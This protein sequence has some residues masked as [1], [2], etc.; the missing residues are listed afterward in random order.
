MKKNNSNILLEN[1]YKSCYYLKIFNQP[2]Y[3]KGVLLQ[4]S[5]FEYYKKINSPIWKLFQ[6]NPESF[7]EVKGEWSLSKLSDLL[8][9]KRVHFNSELSSKYYFFLRKASEFKNNIN[10]GC[11]FFGYK[12]YT[13]KWSENDNEVITLSNIFSIFLDEILEDKQIF[14]PPIKGFKYSK[15]D[16]VKKEYLEDFSDNLTLL[17]K[18][19]LDD[20][21]D[22]VE[23]TEQLLLESKSGH[24][25]FKV[26]ILLPE[27][28][29]FQVENNSDKIP[30]RI[31][32]HRISNSN[33]I[34]ILMKWKYLS[35]EESTWVKYKYFK[36]NYFVKSYYLKNIKK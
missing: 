16:Q 13:K 24:E 29:T 4:I 7:Y 5:L 2:L 35:L 14:Y 6:T 27:K 30:G 3:L 1:L 28:P 18:F 36:H 25:F 11:E 15:F 23:K 19:E 33:K 10:D 9:S 32:D 17:Y 31:I 26:D 20:L 21:F 12:K 8:L 22:D 34:E